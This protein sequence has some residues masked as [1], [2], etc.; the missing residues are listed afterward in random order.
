MDGATERARGTRAG[1]GHTAVRR[2]APWRAAAVLAALTPAAFPFD[3]AE[4]LPIGLL[5]GISDGL[6][7]SGAAVGLL[8]TGHGVTVAVASVPLAH[9]V[10]TVPRRHVLTAL[11]AALVVSSLAAATA[12][13]CGVLL[14]ARLPTAARP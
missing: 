9:A 6:R 8:V 3:T 1:D 7:V 10:R 12:P 14:A 11:L 2:P 5:D 4:N 13:S